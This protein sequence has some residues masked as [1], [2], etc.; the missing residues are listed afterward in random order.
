MLIRVLGCLT[1]F[2]IYLYQIIQ[3]QNALNYLS[4]QI[5][6]LAK[7]VKTLEEENLLLQFRI[8]S[9]ESP[10]HLMKLAHS[11]EYTHLQ[12]PFLEDV[13]ALQAGLA[14][15]V[16]ETSPKDLKESFLLQPVL[17]VGANH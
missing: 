5:P 3:K 4:L 14:I 17:A 10:D 7:E 8:D 16:E 13:T 12:Y 9:F 6:K 15:Q 1:V 2:S 11:P